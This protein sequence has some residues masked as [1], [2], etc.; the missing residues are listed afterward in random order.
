MKFGPIKAEL[1]EVFRSISQHVQLIQ[2]KNDSRLS[3]IQNKQI[4]Y[5]DQTMGSI[6]G[7]STST[8]LG[9]FSPVSKPHT[10]ITYML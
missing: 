10:H 7:I 3:D 2:T 6:T 9:K 4:M 5:I 1:N 8:N